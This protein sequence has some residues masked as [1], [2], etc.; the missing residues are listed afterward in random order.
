[1]RARRRRPWPAASAKRG[2]HSCSRATSHAARGEQ[3][4]ELGGEV[5]VDLHVGRRFARSIRSRRERQ[6][7]QRRVGREVAP[8]EEVPGDGRE[9]HARSIR[10]LKRDFLTGEELGAFELGKLLDRAAELKAGRRERRRRRRRWPGAASPSSSR[11]P[12]PGRGSPSRSASPSSAR[13]RSSCAATR[14][15]SRA[16]SRSATRRGCSRATSTRS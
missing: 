9:L 4:R 14:C 13:R 15:S 7:K 5:A 2:G 8:V 3:R 11:S 1:M 6:V 16:A 12:R 10:G